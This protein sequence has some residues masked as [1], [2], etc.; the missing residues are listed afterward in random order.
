PPG[1]VLIV[2]RAACVRQ[3]QRGFDEGRPPVTAERVPLTDLEQLSVGRVAVR[4]HGR[5]RAQADDPPG[6]LQEAAA[7]RMGKIRPAGAGQTPH[8]TWRWCMW[9]RRS[10]SSTYARSTS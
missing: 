6:A 7:R 3:L 9:T 8:H 1:R 4:A 5:A 10:P 2:A